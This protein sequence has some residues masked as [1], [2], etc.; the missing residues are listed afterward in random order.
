MSNKIKVLIIEDEAAISNF[1]AATLKAN[2]YA[3]LLA[4]TA[5]EA[6]RY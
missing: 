1:I 6:L 4:K 3:P 2:A 5:A